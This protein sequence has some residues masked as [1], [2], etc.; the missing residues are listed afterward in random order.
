MERGVTAERT[1]FAARAGA[2]L[3]VMLAVVLASRIA[4]LPASI[5]EQ[6]EAWL[7]LAVERFDPAAGVPQP[8]WSPLWLAAG[9]GGTLVGLDATRSL[10]VLSLAAGT[11]VLL[12]LLSLWGGLLGRGRGSLAALLFLAAPVV[13]LNA[14]RALT[15]TAASAAL[16]AMCACWCRER[17]SDRALVW[18]SLA[19]AAAFLVRPQLLPAVV[20]PAFIVLATA[21]GARE[22]LRIAVPG[23]ALALAGAA[24]TAAAAGGIEPLAASLARH[25]S[26]H[27]GQL[28]DVSYA[29]ATSGL[30]RGLGHP[31]AAAAWIVLALAGAAGLARS[32]PAT[33]RPPAVPLAARLGALLSVYGVASP[34][35]ARYFIPILAL[36]AGLVVAGAAAL[37]GR[38]APVALAGAIAAFAWQVVP[39]L[40]L[41]RSR[42][43]PPVAA[44][45]LAAERQRETG[46]AV[47]VDRR[48]AA[49]VE[50]E[51]VLG[52]ADL[53]VTWDYEVQ[54][55]LGGVAGA[56]TAIAVF[57]AGHA[58]ALAPATGVERV[59]WPDSAVRRLSPTRYVDVS[60]ATLAPYAVDRAE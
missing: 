2:V 35:H 23:L 29:F 54:L 21:R 25:R 6:D 53:R 48:L 37:L 46:A 38:A 60:V 51:R 44:L 42:P 58:L 30:A 56:D 10:Q 26:L 49:F 5:W 15:E 12:P 8:P 19:A 43:S 34:Q 59:S 22:R 57:D 55:G 40:T 39:G 31:G 9:Y 50:H 18:G 27:F 16:A 24:A 1:G 36:S 33:R 47:V 28:G 3:A 45:R 17:R 20:L 32:A 4:A 41:Y 14:G 52:G 13:W 11:A 7:A